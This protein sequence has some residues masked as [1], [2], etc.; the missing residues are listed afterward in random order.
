MCYPTMETKAISFAHGNGQQALVK[1]TPVSF[2]R[3]TGVANPM[4]DIF[5]FKLAILGLR[6]REVAIG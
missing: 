3:R 6:I 1:A 4:F 5:A 2:G